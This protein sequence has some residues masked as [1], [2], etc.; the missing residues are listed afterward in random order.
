MKFTESIRILNYKFQYSKKTFPGM[1]NQSR[2]CCKGVGNVL[3]YWKTNYV[4]Y[5][6]LVN[7]GCFSDC[8]HAMLMP[9][10]IQDPNMV[11][12]DCRK[13]RSNRI[14]TRPWLWAITAFKV[15][16]NVTANDSLREVNCRISQLLVDKEIDEI[17][18]C[19]GDGSMLVLRIS[20]NIFA[21]TEMPTRYKCTINKV[22][23]LIILI[24]N[25]S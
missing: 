2:M 11:Y 4:F 25:W 24:I 5:R 13:Y 19:L 15:V 9:L 22:A 18:P 14:K 12:N 23:V 20:F 8:S 6:H 1:K 21:S 3:E 7:S 16:N 10:Q 17:L